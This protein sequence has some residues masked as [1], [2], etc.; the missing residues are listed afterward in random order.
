MRDACLVLYLAFP[1]LCHISVFVSQSM[2]C[3]SSLNPTPHRLP[4]LRYPQVIKPLSL[5]M[6]S[7]SLAW[8]PHP[9]SGDWYPRVCPSGFPFYSPCIHASLSFLSR[10]I[11]LL[12]PFVILTSRKESFP[13]DLAWSLVRTSS[14]LRNRTLLLFTD[15]DHVFVHLR[16][17]AL[18][19]WKLCATH[20]L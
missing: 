12:S 13:W 20:P 1:G 11:L 17:S 9:L 4:P 18:E 16:L 8:L 15:S 3:L 14:L 2:L 10:L 6:W 7:N 19:S 5:F